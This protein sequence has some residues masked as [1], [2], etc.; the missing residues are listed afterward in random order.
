VLGPRAA[1][2]MHLGDDVADSMECIPAIG[3]G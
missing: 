3:S 1:A 2:P